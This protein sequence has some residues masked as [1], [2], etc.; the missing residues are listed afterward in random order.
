ADPVGTG[1][2][3]SLAHPG[4]NVTGLANLQTTL[5]PKGL[6]YLAA[7][8]PAAR[9]IAVLWDP[10]TPSHTPARKAV[11][12]PARALGVQLQAAAA[13][14]AAE[15]GEAFAAMAGDGAQAV[16]VIAAVPFFAER[17]RIAELAVTHRLP[18]MFF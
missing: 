6:E 2:V 7:V 16:L 3:A 1:H 9:Q 13:R 12:E 18:T 17:V 14:N 11:E 15:L 5:A 8:V 4:G 10:D